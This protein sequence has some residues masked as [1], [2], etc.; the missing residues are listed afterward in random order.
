MAQLAALRQGGASIRRIAEELGLSPTTVADQGAD[1]FGPLTNLFR[2]SSYREC[3]P[4]L[5]RSGI[6]SMLLRALL[7]SWFGG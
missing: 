1:D 6:T 7:E 3:V 4:E 5:A 2:V